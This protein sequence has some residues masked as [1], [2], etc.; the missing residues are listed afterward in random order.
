MHRHGSFQG[1]QAGSE[2]RNPSGEMMCRRTVRTLG[3]HDCDSVFKI[4]MCPSP[5]I[6][7]CICVRLY[8]LLYTRVTLHF[9][10]TFSL[11]CL[12]IA[13]CLSALFFIP[14]PEHRELGMRTASNSRAYSGMAWLIQTFS[15]TGCCNLALSRGVDLCAKTVTF[16]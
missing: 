7:I 10:R 6:Y 14:A 8:L 2:H 11:C 16:L 9:M 1:L 4:L 13:A 5:H 15:C 12:Y 3:L